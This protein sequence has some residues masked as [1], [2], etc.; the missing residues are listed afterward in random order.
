MKGLA[1]LS[2]ALVLLLAVLSA[3]LRLAHSGIGCSDWPAC[4]GQIGEPPAIAAPTS[5]EDAYRKLVDESEQTLSWATPLHRLVASVLGLLV[6]A[7]FV[8]A[9]RQKRDRLICLGLLAVTVYLAILGIRS[10]S[11]HDPAVVMGNLAGGFAMLGLL[12]WLVYSMGPRG[13]RLQGGRLLIALA[14]LALCLQVLLGGLTSANFAAQACTDLPSCQ[15]GWWPG[16]ALRDALDLSRE[17]A[18]TAAG[19]V[20]G[21][22][23]QVAIQRAHR[24]GALVTTFLVTAAALVGLLGGG[25]FRPVAIFV[26][27]LVAAEL[28]AGALAVIGGVPMILA[29]SHNVL[30]ALLLLAL[31]KLLA[32]ATGA[33]LREKVVPE[34]A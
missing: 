31:L 7:L 2:L 18:V 6:L 10:G 12:G 16:P 34:A 19:Q 28:T 32:L 3:Y 15:G 4:Y 14:L 26:L 24:I 13:Q 27:L 22:P 23:E 25:R 30:A 29:L 5:P 33:R 21:G 8:V 17:H 9:L 1:V 11:L 20:I